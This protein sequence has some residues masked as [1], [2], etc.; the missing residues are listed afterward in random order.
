[1]LHEDISAKRSSVSHPGTWYFFSTS[2]FN[3]LKEL[4]FEENQR[5]SV[6]LIR[7]MT[8]LQLKCNCTLK[9]NISNM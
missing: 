3:P 1:M 2:Q 9:L 4:N 8:G 7:A 6:H 5:S